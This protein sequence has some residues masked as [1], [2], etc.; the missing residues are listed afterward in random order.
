M[1]KNGDIFA[2]GSQDMKSVGIQFIEA[3]R[4]LKLNDVKLKRT[5]HLSFVPGK[6]PL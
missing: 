2:R 5:I 1:D 3:I 6:N 4:R